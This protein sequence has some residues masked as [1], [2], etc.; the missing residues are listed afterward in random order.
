MVY[1]QNAPLCKLK[2]QSYVQKHGI[3]TGDLLYVRNIVIDRYFAGT[4]DDVE[5]V[6]LLKPPIIEFLKELKGKVLKIEEEIQRAREDFLSKV[7]STM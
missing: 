6:L 2:N 7:D 5:D 1:Y 3:V 4:L